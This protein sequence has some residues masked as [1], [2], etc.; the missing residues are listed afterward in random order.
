MRRTNKYQIRYARLWNKLG[1]IHIIYTF[2]FYIPKKEHANLSIEAAPEKTFHKI[3]YLIRNDQTIFAD[4]QT[5][6]TITS[7]GELGHVWSFF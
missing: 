2:S 6:Y 7:K 3:A 1:M 4:I 5:W